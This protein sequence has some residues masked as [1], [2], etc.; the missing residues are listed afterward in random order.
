MWWNVCPV[1]L[2]V[3]EPICI[4]RKHLRLACNSWK[5]SHRNQFSKSSLVLTLRKLPICE[6][7]R[8]LRNPPSKQ[9]TVIS[10][11]STKPLS[12]RTAMFYFALPVT[13]K[14]TPS[15][16]RADIYRMP[17]CSILS[18]LFPVK[19]FDSI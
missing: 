13:H 6:L 11:N 8:K 4:F 19:R 10:S 15:R 9:N 17:I 18:I 5:F 3:W 7:F 12:K 14:N 1:R 16:A 2:Y